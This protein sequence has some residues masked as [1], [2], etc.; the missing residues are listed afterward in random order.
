MNLKRLNQ[1]KLKHGSEKAIYSLT[2]KELDDI[3]EKRLVEYR[4]EIINH[5]FISTCSVF[6]EALSL[7]FGFGKGRIVSLS[8]R[9]K[10]LFDCVTENY[11]E[12]E[13]IEAEIKKK[14]GITFK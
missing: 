6:Y 10:S 8:E 2:K 12:L 7:Q 5:T 14:Y 11:V 1:A 4:A 9:V 13:E 3:I